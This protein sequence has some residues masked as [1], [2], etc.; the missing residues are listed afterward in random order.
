MLH[1]EMTIWYYYPI[2]FGIKFV[3]TNDEFFMHKKS[4]QL[5]Y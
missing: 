4:V 3:F 1:F 5:K 2:F